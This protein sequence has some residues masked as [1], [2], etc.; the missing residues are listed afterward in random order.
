V[1][2]IHAGGP[3]PCLLGRGCYFQITLA[4]HPLQTKLPIAVVN[5]PHP[6]KKRMLVCGYL[7]SDGV[8]HS[9]DCAP[10]CGMLIAGATAHG[11]FAIEWPTHE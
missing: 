2:S 7:A 11:S 4:E 3:C 10:Q 1:V 8:T 9:C 6:R 5:L